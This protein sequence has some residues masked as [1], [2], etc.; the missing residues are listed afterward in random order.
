MSTQI[1][2]DHSQ[3]LKKETLSKYK[4]RTEKIHTH[5]EKP[6]NLN[7]SN[8]SLSIQENNKKLHSHVNNSYDHES[9]QVTLIQ[10]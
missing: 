4:I 8:I 6:L 7:A 1:L 2:K 9:D 10:K 5:S 3:H